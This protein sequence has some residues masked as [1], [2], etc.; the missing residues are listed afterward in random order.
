MTKEEFNQIYDKVRDKYKTT[1]IYD[2]K[3]NYYL[4]SA[5]LKRLRK[6]ALSDK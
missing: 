1:S 4:I 5:L 2:P 3:F 6:D